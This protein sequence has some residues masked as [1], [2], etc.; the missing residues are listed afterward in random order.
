MVRVWI[1]KSNKIDR[2]LFCIS[3]AKQR[4]KKDDFKERL[5]KSSKIF[6]L[7]ALEKDDKL[8]RRKSW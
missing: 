6:C 3:T 4:E 7:D 8:K 2:R 1:D 5:G